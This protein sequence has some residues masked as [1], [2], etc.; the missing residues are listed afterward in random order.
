VETTRRW[1]AS[2][3]ALL[4]VASIGVFVWLSLAVTHGGWVVQLDGHVARWVAANMP[5]AAEWAARVF[6][7]LGSLVSLS[8]L[9]AVAVVVVALRRRWLDA[10]LLAAALI[11]SQFLVDRL[12]DAF[13]RPRPTEGSPV[14]LPDSYSFPSGHAA[15]AVAVFGAIAVALADRGSGRRRLLLVL[16][17]IALAFCVGASRVV[18]NVHYVTDVGAGFCVGVAIL[19]AGLIVRRAILGRGGRR[20]AIARGAVEGDRGPARLGP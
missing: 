20:P 10:I 6:S 13:E 9:T 18:L 4:L 11:V 8:L 12:K 7:W 3:W 14:A 1:A 16:V 2:P 17:T 15:N 19:S 5:S